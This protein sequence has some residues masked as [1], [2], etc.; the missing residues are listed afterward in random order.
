MLVQA[1]HRRD[2][3][4]NCYIYIFGIY[5]RFS[6]KKNSI[7]SHLACLPISGFL[8]SGSKII[9]YSHIQKLPL[10][11]YMIIDVTIISYS[12][13]TTVWKH[14]EGKYYLPQD[15]SPHRD[16]SLKNEIHFGRFFFCTHGST[17]VLLWYYKVTILVFVGIFPPPFFFFWAKQG[18]QI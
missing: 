18:L 6:K 7:H 8:I 3:S 12:N 11:N 16:R 15:L 5:Q 10:T 13:N 1:T 17:I 2:S 14:S 9:L 4:L